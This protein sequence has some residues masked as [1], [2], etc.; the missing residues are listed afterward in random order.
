MIDWVKTNLL[1]VIT[2]LCLAGG[3]IYGY[4][5]TTQKL[6]DLKES[7]ARLEIKLDEISERLARLEGQLLA[8]G[9]LP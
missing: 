6:S 4:G 3:A 7:E 1:V 2:V 8:K 5:Q 9:E